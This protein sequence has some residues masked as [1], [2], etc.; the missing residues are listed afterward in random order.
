MICFKYIFLPMSFLSLLKKGETN[1]QNYISSLRKT[2]LEFDHLISRYLSEIDLK[3]FKTLRNKLASIYLEYFYLGS[4]PSKIDMSLINELIDFESQFEELSNHRVF[5]LAFYL[6]LLTLNNDDKSSIIYQ[7]NGELNTDF[8]FVKKINPN[9]SFIDWTFLIIYL[10]SNNSNQDLEKEMS[11]FK[12]IEGL[13]QNKRRSF[14][15]SMIS[16]GSS[17]QESN[18]FSEPIKE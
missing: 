7:P 3:D 16:Y 9:S 4:F 12:M 14:F 5:L 2:D 18:V 13:E 17:I 10:I 11:V 15:N 1:Y 8:E 6:K